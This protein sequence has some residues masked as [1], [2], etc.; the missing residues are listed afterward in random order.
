MLQETARI[1]TRRRNRG[2]NK[3][4]SAPILRNIGSESGA[5]KTAS[6][7]DLSSDALLKTAG[8]GPSSTSS[9]QPPPPPP[10]ALPQPA[11]PRPG[12]TTRRQAIR[13]SASTGGVDRKGGIIFIPLNLYKAPRLLVASAYW[14]DLAVAKLQYLAANLLASWLPILGIMLL[15]SLLQPSVLNTVMV[16][17]WSIALLLPSRRFLFMA[18]VLTCFSAV[19]AF[20]Q[21]LWAIPSLLQS[22]AT[23]KFIGVA[24]SHEKEAPFLIFLSIALAL[25]LSNYIRDNSYGNFVYSCKKQVQ[26]DMLVRAS[27][28]GD[29]VPI[30]LAMSS[31]HRSELL[32]LKD[33]KGL[34]LLHLAAK[35][36]QVT[37]VQKLLQIPDFV[38]NATCRHGTALHYAARQGFDGV[39]M[40]LLQDV[41]SN[42]EIRNDLGQTFY[43]VPQK[44]TTK[45]LRVVRLVYSISWGLFLRYVDR[46]SIVAIFLIGCEKVNVYHIGFLVISTIFAVSPEIARKYWL[47]LGVYSVV[48]FVLI[49][50][51]QV[52]YDNPGV[53]DYSN[54]NFLLQR[55]SNNAFQT[56]FAY[57]SAVALASLQMWLYRQ[58][59]DADKVQ[60]SASLP[61]FGAKLQLQM[62]LMFSSLFCVSTY[63]LAAFVKGKANLIKFSYLV[64]F[65]ILLMVFAFSTKPLHTIKRFWLLV[66][67][68]SGII[69]STLFVYQHPTIS[70]SIEKYFKLST[71]DTF[72]SLEDVGLFKLEKNQSAS[73]FLDRL[74]SLGPS[75]LAFWSSVMFYRAVTATL[76]YEEK[77]GH[78]FVDSQEGGAT[79]LQAVDSKD[80]ITEDETLQDLGSGTDAPDVKKKASSVLEFNRTLT[81]AMLLDEPAATTATLGLPTGRRSRMLP[82]T[83]RRS[84]NEPESL[85]DD[86]ENDRNRNAEYKT[87]LPVSISRF[88]RLVVFPAGTFDNLLGAVYSGFCGSCR[89]SDNMVRRNSISGYAEFH[90]SGDFMHF[91]SCPVVQSDAI[92]IVC[93][94]CPVHFSALHRLLRTSSQPCQPDILLLWARAWLSMG[95]CSP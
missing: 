95:E 46:L 10:P 35:H 70:S 17:M 75:T 44:C 18:P 67:I 87:G 25:C 76:A 7:S 69:V 73:E 68:Y 85:S 56:M 32:H 15:I 60:V 9:Q 37:V 36:G 66:V 91:Y 62:W 24:I 58:K 34:T 82:G 48:V 20:L 77:H 61:T 88:F 4:N 47:L 5:A 13:V 26:W 1:V 51:M 21:Y 93:F 63:V 42:P 65:L 12:R 14:F 94:W 90:V 78:L 31:H 81:S 49:Y 71:A 30:E 41:R 28:K 86:E 59:D 92:R 83:P 6:Q 11:S 54:S 22:S 2:I 84:I 53:F 29:T 43:Q 33:R 40:V 45:V 72:L 27:I 74:W 19:V 50:I 3:Y 38:V 52:L 57:Y 16:V 8:V 64:A 23:L 89:S 79:E 55:D 39:I 80:E